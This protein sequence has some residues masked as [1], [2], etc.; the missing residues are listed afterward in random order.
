MLNSI[1]VGLNRYDNAV[2]SWQVLAIS[3]AR[4]SIAFIQRYWCSNCMQVR[5][6][7][8]PSYLSKYG[9]VPRDSYSHHSYHCEP[10]PIAPGSHPNDSPLVGHFR[11]KPRTQCRVSIPEICFIRE[12][13]ERFWSIFFA[14]ESSLSN[15]RTPT[16]AGEC[17]NAWKTDPNSQP[18]HEQ[19]P[20]IINSSHGIASNSTIASSNSSLHWIT[21]SVFLLDFNRPFYQEMVWRSSKHQ[22]QWKITNTDSKSVE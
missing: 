6:H 21:L 4:W 9:L 10:A 11:P 1:L 15:P 17:Y 13:I 7:Y 18:R 14:D 16:G 8:L 12:V 22:W 20:H 19:L 5:L 2:I 3:R